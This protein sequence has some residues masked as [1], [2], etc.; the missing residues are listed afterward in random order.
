MIRLTEL[1]EEDNP[2]TARF[3]SEEDVRVKSKGLQRIL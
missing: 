3:N 2:E 1:V